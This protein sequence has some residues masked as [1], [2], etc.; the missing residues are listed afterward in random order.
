[1]LRSIIP[2]PGSRCQQI[3]FPR[4]DRVQQ[5]WRDRR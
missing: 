5:R 3:L 4:Y 2:E 1:L